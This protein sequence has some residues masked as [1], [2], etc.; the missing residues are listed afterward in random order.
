MIWE[1][2]RDKLEVQN[3]TYSFIIKLSAERILFETCIL[4]FGQD[5]IPYSISGCF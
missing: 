2:N 4:V 3:N 1:H 5:K